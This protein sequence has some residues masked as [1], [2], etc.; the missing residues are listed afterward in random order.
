MSARQ[1]FA[2]FIKQNKTN[3]A[4][5]YGQILADKSEVY[6]KSSTDGRIA[7]GRKVLSA[8]IGVF[9]GGQTEVLH[10]AFDQDGDPETQPMLE[11]EALGDT[12]TPVVTSLEAGKFLWEILS[13]LRQS[14]AP[15]SPI[16]AK[17]VVSD[18]EAVSKQS[19]P[20]QDSILRASEERYR[21]ILDSIEDGYY[22][23]DL[24]GN[25][26]FFNDALP[27]VLGYPAE[28]LMGMNNRDYTDEENGKLLY[29]AFRQVFDTQQ[30]I[31]GFTWEVT[32]K[33]GTKGFVENSTSLMRNAAGEP[34]GFRGV[35][36]EVTER[37]KAQEQI[38]RS[39][40]QLQTT[41]SRMPVPIV[42]TRVKDGTVLYVNEALSELFGASP[43][44]L[45]GQ[46]SPDFYND[47]ADRQKVVE[48]MTRDGQI[49][50]AELSFKRIDGSVFWASFSIHPITFFDEPAFL[51]GFYN[52]TERKEAETALQESEERLSRLTE[53]TFEAI[54]FAEKG[55][56]LDVNPQFS[57]L[58]GYGLDEAIGMEVT[59]LVSPEYRDLV[60][61]HIASNYQEPYEARL[62][63]KDGSPFWA[64]I[65]GKSTLYEGRSVRVTAIQD[66]SARK[67]AE[68]EIRQGEERLQTLLDS[69][70]DPI[71]TYDSIGQVTYLN[72]AFTETF[73][74]TFDE[75]KGQRIDFVPEESQA[76]TGEAIKRLIEDGYV[77]RFD[78]KRLTKSGQTLDVE[79]SG[80]LYRDNDGEVVGSIVFIRDI[81]ERKAAEEELLIT[82]YSIDFSND[83]VF[84]LS[85]DGQILYANKGASQTLGYTPDELMTMHVRDIDP[86]VKPEIRARRMKDL[87]SGRETIFESRHQAKDGRIFPVE[88]RRNHLEI[89]EQEYTFVFARDITERK[90]TEEALRIRTEAIEASTEPIS[91]ADARQPDMPLIYVNPAFEKT[92]GYSVDEV[93]GKNC[94]FLQGDDT[95]QPDLI[96]LRAALKE[97]RSTVVTLRN[98]KK[99]GTLFWNELHISP[100]TNAQG[101]VIYFLG[102]Q[103]DVTQMRQAQDSLRQSL[104]ET[105][106]QS[107]R[108]SLLNELATAL[109]QVETED[110]AFRSVADKT[111]R[112]VEVDRASVA[113]LNQTKDE[114]EVFSLDGVAGAIPTG[115]HLPIAG[116]QIGKA[117]MDRRMVLVNDA[118]ESNWLDSQKL[119]KA[120]LRSLLNA[121]LI[122]GGDVI[123]TLNVGSKQVNAYSPQD[124][125]LLT[126]IASMLATTLENKRLLQEAQDRSYRL[127]RVSQIETNLTQATTEAEILTALALGLP[128][129]PD[130]LVLQFIETDQMDQPLSHTPVAVWQAGVIQEDDLTLNQRYQF[131]QF[132][133]NQYLLD[134]PNEIAFVSDVTDDERI[135]EA[136]QELFGKL[137]VAAF[138][139]VP[140][141]SGNRWQG[142]LSFDWHTPHD[143]T[144]DEKFILEELLE[145]VA[146]V[147]AS[148][149]ATLAQ[150]QAL[151]ETEALYKITQTLADLTDPGEMAAAALSQY[152]QRLNL[153]QGGVALYDDDYIE[154]T[155]IA[156]MK[157][158]VLVDPGTRIPVQGSAA[159]EALVNT[160]APVVV[161]DVLTDPR[162]ED[163]REF[164]AAMGLTSLLM[165]PIL[166]QGKVIGSL[167]ADSV[168]KIYEFT[169]RDI[170]FVKAVA[171]R[172]GVAFENQRLTGQTQQSYLENQRLLIQ[173]ERRATQLEAVSKV[174]TAASTV[175]E[176]DTL[177][178]E[179]VNLIRDQFDFYYVGLFLL[180]AAREWAILRAGT[181]QAG[182]TQLERK[183][184][185]QI[186]GQ[187]MIGWSITNRQARIA[188]DVGEDAV[189][190]KNPILPDTRSE[191]ALP[192]ISRDEVLG[193]LTVQS[194]VQN[195]F[196]DADITSLQAMADQVANAIA[197]SRLLEQT[198]TALTET[199][200]LYESSLKL[201]QASSYDEILQAM[202]VSLGRENIANAYLYTIDLD[203]NGSPEWIEIVAGWIAT[204]DLPF[205]LGHR[206]YLPDFPGSN[207][208]INSPEDPFMIGDIE[209]VNDD[210]V[211]E[212]ARAVYRQVG[213]RA[214]IILPLTLGD[215][216]VGLA[217]V[218]WTHPQRFTNVDQRLYQA[219]ANQSAVLMNNQLLFEQTEDRANELA[220]LNELGRTLAGSLNVQQVVTETYIHTSQLVDATNCFIGLYKPEQDEIEFVLNM[221]ESETD[222]NIKTIP[223]NKGLSGYVV[224]HRNSLLISND[225]V[226]WL[227]ER[228]LEIVG[229]VKTKS[230]LGVPLLSGD[231]LIGVIAVHS[232]TTPNLYTER[233]KDLLMAVANQTVVAIQNARQFEQAQQRVEFE[234]TL[235]Q[236]TS[237]VR[238]SNDVELI[239]RTA[240][241]ELGQTL[242]RKVFVSLG[243]A[244]SFTEPRPSQPENGEAHF[245]EENGHG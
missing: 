208:W 137:G 45:I 4:Q 180:D 40:E 176:T 96:E 138:A 157:N 80:A 145:D 94:R 163:Q 68:Q 26:T 46:K 133:F 120:G 159:N 204:G 143:F 83:S 31:K 243:D 6:A 118:L 156:H 1:E 139:T 90:Q 140:L 181:G 190:F 178:D 16:N 38:R 66:I 98:Y 170:D 219:I 63:R 202:I 52:L 37:N 24:T 13:E 136:L 58:F 209:D 198:Q 235:Q 114:L 197:N 70:P 179:V 238:S 106:A 174:S 28:E 41:L 56:I 203:K 188:L 237:Q 148:R 128:E 227:K 105:E 51:S 153:P 230:W 5:S 211:D 123:G 54:V 242:Q 85:P 175:L 61:G 25:L 77:R 185:L 27:A 173:M 154:G 103:N 241:Q 99:D 88:I 207:Q 150:E 50:N 92:T 162:F 201:S 124:Q 102:S 91:I 44:E 222:R 244:Q 110:D 240:V 183:H 69:A 73:G 67:Q 232:Y 55:T 142:L 233:D 172:L 144:A 108:L 200:L 72:P 107:T 213:I 194:T 164:V 168:D 49:T 81:T 87:R 141:R 186:G 236:I 215:Q 147:V 229:D 10:Q 129:V 93:I 216:W 86:D 191:M 182:R 2:N 117:V 119:G 155:L 19:Q 3:L 43:T 234:R 97:G 166:R 210:K 195:A 192:L 47:P 165:V 53:A 127:E 17:A 132:S 15:L 134:T 84:R 196:S 226:G 158:R 42:V 177:L 152:L 35:A 57:Q 146:A 18:S 187:S 130:R 225:I 115:T 184:R 101:E 221:T 121:P 104:V 245:P 167:G 189:Q 76:E 48:M 111:T 205:P 149:R 171:D 231:Q 160:K 228:N 218:S 224:T 12:L 217:N 21:D 206:F 113:L 82:Q 135:G 193:A 100:V 239:M 30:P 109:S 71:V 169:E 64:Q 220:V 75:V 23:V 199:N 214:I 122:I 79:Q 39:E 116:T 212:N 161:T 126:Q 151:A 29:R 34:I 36:R 74:W 22:E 59:P 125:Q 11:I 131:D 65:L 62:Q 20:D 112:I 78:T 33:D 95:D 60:A 9:E 14:F 32:H 223:A 7:K 8:V 89:G